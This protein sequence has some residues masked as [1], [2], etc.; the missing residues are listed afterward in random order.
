RKLLWGSGGRTEHRVWT[1]GMQLSLPINYTIDVP[2]TDPDNLYLV[3]FAQDKDTR[4]IL[5]SS[6]IKVPRKVGVLPVGIEDNPYLAEI[7]NIHVFPN[8]ASKE[9]WFALDNLLSHDYTYR[10]IDPRGVTTLEGSLNDD[11]RVPQ[12]VDLTVLSNGIYFVQF[13]NADNKVVTYRKLAVMNRQ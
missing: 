13:R 11:L 10:I 8:P 4:H 5:Q 3:T 2:I 12:N 9:V 6:I 7:G 1:E